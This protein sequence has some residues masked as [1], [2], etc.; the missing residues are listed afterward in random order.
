MMKVFDQQQMAQLCQAM[1]EMIDHFDPDEAASLAIL[2]EPVWSF[3]GSEEA[4]KSVVSVVTSYFDA[5]RGFHTYVASNVSRFGPDGGHRHKFVRGL[6]E[7]IYFCDSGHEKIDFDGEIV[8][9][10]DEAL[11]HCEGCDTRLC[12]DCFKEKYPN[13]RVASKGSVPARSPVEGDVPMWKNEIP[14]NRAGK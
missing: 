10:D 14:W 2:W 6:L 5:Y 11:F 12:E 13:Y 4:Q 7:V 1:V 3:V 9:A 8:P